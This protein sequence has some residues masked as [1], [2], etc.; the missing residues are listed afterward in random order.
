MSY[1]WDGYD[2]IFNYGSCPPPNSK[3]FWGDENPDR[4]NEDEIITSVDLQASLQKLTPTEKEIILLFNKGYSV[5]EIEEMINLPSSTVQD[6][7]QRAIAKL[8]EM[9]N[10]KDSIHCFKGEEL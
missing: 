5:R 8:K 2:K 4:F 7:K 10:G 1:R 3:P 6:I 9:M